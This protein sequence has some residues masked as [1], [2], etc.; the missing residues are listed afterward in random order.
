MAFTAKD[1]QA[2][3]EKTGVG[4]MDCKKALTE[5]DGDFD[6]AVDILRERG[7]AAATKKAGRITAEGVV[8]A[9]FDEAS[10]VAVLVEV[11]S[12]TDFVGKN[13]EFQSFVADIAKTVREENPA[14]VDALLACKLSGAD[15][16]VEEMRQEKVLS[17]GEN[18]SIRRFVRLEGNAATYVH[19]G[20]S[21][22][23]LVEFATDD[24]TAG[25]DAF[26]AMGKD[27]AMQVAA[28]GALY[29]DKSSVPADVVE[30]EKGILL[31]QIAEDPKMANKPEKVL[32]GIVQ[33]KLGKYYSEFCLLEQPFVKDEDLTVA[34]YIAKVAKALG[35]SIEATGFTRYV[36]GENMQKKEDD[37]AAEVAK[38]IQ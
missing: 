12:E 13:A 18:L 24:A 2:L 29:L 8:L 6:R 17:I 19:G 38:M 10:K 7:L 36:K 32:A 22:G 4:M 16:S 26:K 11:N 35:A 25:S 27:I 37:F 31:A 30:H 28:M 20:G 23:V 3:R 1:V 33:G 9:V 34:A 21:M 14:D 15:R 5:A